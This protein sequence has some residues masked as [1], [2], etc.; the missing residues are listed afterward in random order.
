MKTLKALLIVLVSTALYNC[1]QMNNRKV[2]AVD[3]DSVV[4]V[5]YND[6]VT[7]NECV[8]DKKIPN[9]L[10]LGEVVEYIGK[11]KE[12]VNML[13]QFKSYHKALL[14]GDIDNAIHYQYQDAAKYFRKYYPGNS[15]DNVMRKIFEDLS[16][17]TIEEVKR[18][19]SHG[20]ELN[21]VVSRVIRKV[22]QGD[23]IFYV[24]EIVSNMTNEKLQLHT[25]PDLT[26]G[27]STNRGRNWTFNAMNEDTPNILRISFPYKIVDMVMGY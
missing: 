7:I 20:V 16:M 3:T 21:I 10:T 11:N 26:L 17:K 18:F 13:N 24:F 14:R 2:A 5:E 27:V 1:G 25:T 4:E 15:D 23:N 9:G 8:S 6:E 19:E 22:S 12:E